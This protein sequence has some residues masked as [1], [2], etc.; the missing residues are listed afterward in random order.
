MT[1]PDDDIEATRE[2]P[3]KTP[4]ADMSTEMIK[5]ATEMDDPDMRA[6]DMRG[7]LKNIAAAAERGEIVGS[8]GHKYTS[9]SID[10]QLKL[11]VK[12]FAHGPKEEDDPGTPA[13][14]FITG[15]KGLRNAF[16]ALISNDKTSAAFFDAINERVFPRPEAEEKAE[17]VPDPEIVEEVGETGVNAAELAEQSDEFTM[18][19]SID[20]A[21][22]FVGE[23]SPEEIAADTEEAEALAEPE[24]ELV[25]E[26]DTELETEGI[27]AEIEVSEPEETEEEV[28]IEKPEKP[29]LEEVTKSGKY[30]YD[31]K[32]IATYDGLLQATEQG[33]GRIEGHLNDLNVVVASLSSIGESTTQLKLALTH[34][35]DYP[36]PA[37]R[38]MLTNLNNSLQ[39]YYNAN[40][41]VLDGQYGAYALMSNSALSIRTEVATIAKE[42]GKVE[43]DYTDFLNAEA[44]QHPGEEMPEEALP[45]K[46]SLSDD[47]SEVASK[48]NEFANGNYPA[49]DNL[50]RVQARIMSIMNHLD[51]MDQTAARG[52]FDP[53][54]IQSVVSQIN[55]IGSDQAELTPTRA[56]TSTLSELRA[57]L[58]SAG[59]KVGLQS[60][61][62]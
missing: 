14:H 51:N 7:F 58:T 23:A 27:P 37:V 32:V 16:D 30:E 6:D 20:K 62:E 25:A 36:T 47:L 57:K 52:F 26:A 29:S 43:D 54:E 4:Y 8:N 39:L 34:I 49:E 22:L 5:R 28:K 15:T 45:D 24:A 48:L 40:N 53:E 35:E 42:L 50:T 31:Q 60:R 21:S 33:F 10:D 1:H 11:F 3:S 41:Q 61:S 46:S 19:D 9:E 55:R 44:R 13:L 2:R 17:F 59:A 18:E 38:T 12:A 56:I